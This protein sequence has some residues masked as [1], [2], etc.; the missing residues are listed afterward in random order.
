M[1]GLLG[2]GATA[3]VAIAAFR[4]SR[5]ANKATIKAAMATT[6]RTVGAARDTNQATSALLLVLP[7]ARW[8]LER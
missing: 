5:P 3:A 8:W 1:A 7:V 6:D 4:C 2:V